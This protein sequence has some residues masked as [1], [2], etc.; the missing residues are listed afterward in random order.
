ML[1]KDKYILFFSEIS[2]KDLDL[3]GGKNAALGQMVKS[4]SKKRIRV[5]KGF[6]V[7]SKTYYDFIEQG[8]IKKQISDILKKLDTSDTAD[9]Q[10]RGRQVRSLIM[11]TE[12]S[13]KL[14]NEITVAYKKLA[15]KYQSKNLSVAVRSSATAE[16]L[17]MASFAGQLESFLN[18][19]GREE[20]LKTVKK[21]FASLFTNRA[22]S[23]R[24]DKGFSLWQVAISVGVQKMVRSDKAGAGVMFTLEPESGFPDLVVINAG[25]GLGENLVKGNIS[26]DEFYVYKNKLKNFKPIIK[27]SLGGKKLTMI[28]DSLNNKAT[29][30]IK[31]SLKK[32][33]SFTLSDKEILDLAK[34]GV[35]IEKHFKKPMDIEWAK[36]GKDGKL[37]IV[38]ARPETVHS[39]KK[40]KTINKYYLAEKTEIILTGTAVGSKVSA[41]KVKIIKSVNQIKKFK[42]GEILV[43]EMT[44]PSWEPIMKKAAGIITEKGGRT[45][46]AAIVSREL[47]VPCLVGT[48]KAME[49]LKNNQKITIDC[50]Q[51]AKGSVYQG[52][53]NIKKSK[54]DLKKIKLPKSPDIMMNMGNPEVAF[55]YSVMPNRGVGLARQEFII[56]NYIGIHPLALIEYKKLATKTQKKIDKKTSGYKLKSDFYIDKLAEGIGQIAAAFY[57]KPVIVRFSDFKTGEYKNLIAGK[58][59]EP[60]ESNPMIGWRGASRYYDDKFKPA[61]TLELEAIKKVKKNFGLDNLQVMIP[62]CRSVEEAR[63]VLKIIKQN[64]LKRSKKFKIYLMCELPVNV[65]QAEEFLKLVDG[66]SIGSNDLTQL[67]LGVDRDS[68]LVS[69]I[70]DEFNSAVKKSIAKVIQIA[71]KMN[72]KVGFC[73]QAPS[74]FPEFAEFLAKKNISGISVTPDSVISVI[75]H[76]QNNK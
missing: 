46:H 59:Y 37:Y 19:K 57:P 70:Y 75:K 29:K 16:D 40:R 27:K 15:K 62:F 28:Y 36:D 63:K 71:K 47:G 2:Q 14:Q 35:E 8:G 21:C 41:G 74:D 22:I 6:A 49:V 42:K 1:K 48:E 50:S 43:A 11:K 9:L 65:W 5:P 53:L 10:K 45:C 33:N 54:I 24:Q 20:L 60:E 17:P 66:Y 34:W 69:H 68:E 26:P 55:K 3:V 51:G 12:F 18:I 32:K 23:Y 67:T 72:K 30:N 39:P 25:W 58:I 7:N 31:T 4:L 44:D 13:E 61:F 56:S 73:G 52:A 76:L 38:Q 64:G